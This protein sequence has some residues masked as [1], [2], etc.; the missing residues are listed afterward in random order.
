MLR[1]CSLFVLI[2]ALP[3]CAAAAPR[4]FDGVARVIDGDTL[5]VSGERVRLHG[6]DAVEA[7]QTCRPRQ[8][9]DWDCGTWVTERVRAMVEGREVACDFVEYDR[10]GRSVARCFLGGADIGRT[11]VQ[12]GL[13]FAYRKYSMDYDLDEK[14]AFVADRGLH[15][16]VMQTPAQHRLTR[17]KGREAPDA[18]CAIKGNISGKGVRIYHVPGQEHYDRTGI[19]TDKGERWFCSQAEARAAGWR[20]A[21]R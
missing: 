20:A 11:L 5:D 19:R 16:F 21:R 8:G 2:V 10:Y 3:L 1:I 15:G 17:T 6:I 9:P 14:A 4:Q 12:E 18:D 13:A 7:G